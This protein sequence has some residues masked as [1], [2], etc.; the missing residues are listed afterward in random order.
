MNNVEREAQELWGFNHFWIIYCY[1]NIWG[2]LSLS[3]SLSCKFAVQIRTKWILYDKCILLWIS[4]CWCGSRY[5]SV[6]SSLSLGAL[7]RNLSFQTLQLNNVTQV[8]SSRHTVFPRISAHPL[9]YNVKQAPPSR[10]WGGGDSL[11]L[12]PLYLYLLSFNYKGDQYMRIVS[13]P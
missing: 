2:P 1:L 6:D 12:L 3:I 9:G 13:F 5:D 7:V 11:F 10:Y 4:V 8:N